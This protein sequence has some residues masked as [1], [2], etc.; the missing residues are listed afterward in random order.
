V[1]LAAAAAP[2]AGVL[3]EESRSYEVLAAEDSSP[4]LRRLLLNKTMLRDHYL[5]G[6]I[7]GGAAQGSGGTAGHTQS[8]LT[9]SGDWG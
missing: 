7:P 4:S 5:P 9:R 6:G 2:V 8:P 3:L 1:L